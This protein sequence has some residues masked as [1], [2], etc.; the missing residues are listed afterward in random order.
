M[1]KVSLDP[2][3]G[4]NSFSY[5]NRLFRQ[6]FEYDVEDEE[7][8]VALRKRKGI[9]VWVEG[10]EPE[11]EPEPEDDKD[12]ADTGFVAHTDESPPPTA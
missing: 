1:A 7:T 8:L 12:G 10:S 5:N 4:L 3:T 9:N 2:E 6:G 11:P